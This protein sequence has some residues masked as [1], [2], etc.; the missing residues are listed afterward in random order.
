MM[1]RGSESQGSPKKVLFLTVGGFPGIS[2]RG[3]YTDLLRKFRDHGHDVVV[4]CP[5][6]RR[7]NRPTELI[8][9]DGVR[10][11]RVRILN[12]TKTNL[13]EKAIATITIEGRFR[14]ELRR[15]LGG[16]QFD[17]IL[18]STPPVTF[19]RVV[20]ALKRAGSARSYLLLKDIFPQNAVD[21]G[22]MR[23]G[24]VVWRYFR[25]RERH[26]Y[27]VSD[28]IGCMSPANVRHVLAHNPEIPAD[29][30]E[31]CPNAVEPRAARE[32]TDMRAE[33]RRRLGFADEDVVLVYGGN[34][35]RPQG[36]E[37]ILEVLRR[38]SEVPRVRMLLVGSGTEYP[39]IAA[40]AGDDPTGRIRVM[41]SV[42][43]NEYDE[44]LS[45]ADIGL[46]FL[47]HRF[48]I[49]NF[50]SRML[51]YLEASVPIIAATDSATDVGQVLV[52]SNAGLS[53]GSDDV[54]AFIRTVNELADS[55]GR[56]E[57]MGASARRLLEGSYTADMAYETIARRMEWL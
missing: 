2:E 9:D 7:E 12:L 6:E 34:F 20:S 36:V 26:L 56:R 45:A 10:I 32:F 39:R 25:S 19:D 35:G 28:W 1:A 33:A 14:R 13:I 38:V 5:I 50:P 27:A 21:L 55:P 11:L 29:R 4:A 16:E 24:G 57:E 22:M 15:H 48:T 31:V 49:P 23:R 44:I 17:L 51:G 40:A 54:E 47:D 46:L 53:V 52:E 30:V 37:F 18:Y 41:P 3:I 42:G 8:A 43:R